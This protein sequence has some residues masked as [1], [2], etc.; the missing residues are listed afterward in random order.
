MKGKRNVLQ[1][2]EMV[3]ILN[4]LAL[5]IGALAVPVP[6]GERRGDTK[7]CLA[8]IIV[9]RGLEQPHLERRTSWSYEGEN[10]ASHW[11]QFNTVCEAGEFQSPINFEGEKFAIKLKPKLSW[12]SLTKPFNVLNNGHTIQLQLKESTPTL[13]SK[14]VNNLDY[15]VQQVHFHSP[16]EHHIDEKYF[17]LEA[18][19]VHASTDG[20]LSVIGLLF[21]AGNSKKFEN[22]W[23]KQFENKL[24]S[25]TNSTKPLSKLDM[26]PIIKAL[27]Y[28]EFFSYTGSLTTPPCTEGVLWLVAKEP[29]KISLRQLDKL[30]NSM[31]FNSRTT[32]ANKSVGKNTEGEHDD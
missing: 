29:L 32:Q 28:A 18:H 24:P 9:A 13:S 1:V 4:A 25:T 8:D 5:A 27:K 12:A 20:K 10:G 30:R 22:K 17:D 14:Q 7:N 6:D 2:V 15:I 21:E 26:S 23:I 31:P 16:S 19:F 11:G 3:S